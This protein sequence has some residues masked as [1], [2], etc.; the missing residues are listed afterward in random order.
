MTQYIENNGNQEYIKTAKISY[1][2]YL[3][4]F[5]SFLCLLSGSF[6]SSCIGST[7]N[8]TEVSIEKWSF[9]SYSSSYVYGVV[10]G[11]VSNCLYYLLRAYN[12]DTAII[13]KVNTDL[14]QAWMTSYLFT[15]YAN[16]ISVDLTEANVYIGIASNVM[17]LNT[18][19]G[20]LVSINSL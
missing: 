3:L 12:S 13:R 6:A 10:S 20:A 14:T 15:S 7:L 4:L 9:T 17:R 16:S 11:K 2:G 5:I 19:T 1:Y 18:S 8:S